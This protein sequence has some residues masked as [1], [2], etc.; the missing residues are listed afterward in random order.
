MLELYPPDVLLVVASKDTSVP[1]TGLNAA[2][3]A[4]EQTA[5]P[6]NA[7]D[8]SEASLFII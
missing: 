3:M 2:L 4:F 8:D 5:L 6:R 1:D 7:F